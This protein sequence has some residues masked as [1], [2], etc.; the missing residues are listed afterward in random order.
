[1]P[2]TTPF[3][4]D[5]SRMVLP[6][7]MGKNMPSLGP[8]EGCVVPPPAFGRHIATTHKSGSAGHHS[9]LVEGGRANGLILVAVGQDRAN[10]RGNDI[11]HGQPR[12]VGVEVVISVY[13]AQALHDPKVR[14]GECEC[15]AVKVGRF[16]TSKRGKVS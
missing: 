12:P 5:T 11:A 6:A 4:R 9:F 8:V 2:T 3:G 1:M 10:D 7:A 16:P 15:L 14:H 13:E